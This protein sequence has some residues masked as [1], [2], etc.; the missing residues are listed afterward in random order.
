[1]HKYNIVAHPLTHPWLELSSTSHKLL[2]VLIKT[3]SL[4]QGLASDF[5][6]MLPLVNRCL[7]FICSVWLTL[8][9]SIDLTIPLHKFDGSHLQDSYYAFLC[10][11]PKVRCSQC[12]SEYA[13]N[14]LL[15]CNYIASYHTPH[16][17]LLSYTHTSLSHM[18][19]YCDT[20]THSDK[21]TTHTSLSLSHIRMLTHTL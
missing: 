9:K 20:L 1:M 19:A 12:S 21:H 8:Q 18:R 10:V 14:N 7:F 16:T 15:V 13:C 3:E 5:T 11:D 4:I 17:L 2:S 6:W